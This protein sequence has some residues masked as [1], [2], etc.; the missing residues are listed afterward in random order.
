MIE[1]KK[2]ENKAGLVNAAFIGWQ[3]IS[4]QASR[5]PGFHKYVKD[6]GIVDEEEGEDPQVTR[7]ELERERQKSKSNFDAALAAFERGAVKQP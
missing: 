4:A 7:R 3:V 2:S 6:L 1:A 5:M